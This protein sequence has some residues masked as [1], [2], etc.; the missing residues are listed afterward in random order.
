MAELLDKSLQRDKGN[1]F[2]GALTYMQQ[3]KKHFTCAVCGQEKLRTEGFPLDMIRPAVQKLI[4]FEHPGLSSGAYIC[5]HDLQLYRERYLT[6]LL[7]K[8]KGELD[9]LEIEVLRSMHE[10]ELV[11]LN[12]NEEFS[13]V[14]T[15]GERFSDRIARFGGSW[16]FIFSFCGVLLAWVI[17]N[18]TQLLAGPFD[19]YPFILLNLFLSCLAAIQA[20]VILMSQ[21]RQESKDRLRAEHDYQV[22]LKAEMEIRHLNE[23]LDHLMLR[24]W[25]RLLE[26]QEIQV[27]MLEEL[28]PRR[29]AKDGDG[30]GD[31]SEKKG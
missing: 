20:P 5:L 12:L 14:Q 24:Q 18:S 7:T 22:N 10:H 15:L 2:K 27:Q 1:Q 13:E 25:Q 21:N 29:A 4:L 3:G 30:L 31:H 8:E 26:I 28:G 17:V 9:D 16:T 23:K 19:P 6:E 11:S